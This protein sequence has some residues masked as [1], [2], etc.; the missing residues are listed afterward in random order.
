M[1]Y[2]RAISAVRYVASLMSDLL[3]GV[4]GEDTGSPAA[5]T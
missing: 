2:S 3:L 1:R 4:Y 5:G